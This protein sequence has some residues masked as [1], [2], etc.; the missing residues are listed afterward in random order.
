MRQLLL[1]CVVLFAAAG[2]ATAP[3]AEEAAN[4]DYGPRPTADEFR[5]TVEAAIKRKLKD[6]GSAQFQYPYPA[7]IGWFTQPFGKPT[8]Y[9]Y[10]TCGL[11]NAKNSFGGYTGFGFF[12]AVYNNGRVIHSGVAGNGEYDST[13]LACEKAIDV[14]SNAPADEAIRLE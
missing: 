4:A 5:S 13:R 14:L 7:M 11:V 12:T 9:G 8:L 6:P 10:W 2:C 3:T 1:I